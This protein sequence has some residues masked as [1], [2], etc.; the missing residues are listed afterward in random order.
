MNSTTSV[1]SNDVDMTSSSLRRSPLDESLAEACA[2]F[3]AAFGRDEWI[4][5]TFSNAAYLPLLDNWAEGIR[6]LGHERRILV[7]CLDAATVAWCTHRRMGH[8]AQ[9]PQFY[10]RCVFVPRAGIQMSGT[11]QRLWC[12]RTRVFA[13]LARLGRS[14]VHSDT[15]AVWMR[16]PFV[17]G[18]LERRPSDAAAQRWSV[19]FSRATRWPEAVYRKWGFVVCCGLFAVVST[20]ATIVFWQRVRSRTD[21][22]GDDQT[23][24]NG[25]LCNPVYHTEWTPATAD[26]FVWGYAAGGVDP[27]RQGS[28]AEESFS[29]LLLPDHVA[30][31]P[32]GRGSSHANAEDATLAAAVALGSPTG[33]PPYIVHPVVYGGQRAHWKVLQRHGAVFASPPPSSSPSASNQ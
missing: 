10:A 6:R 20:P 23:A 32:T 33:G 7:V 17:T 22:C 8:W 2:A 15:D 11:Q 4:L 30:S 16:D 1:E 25:V 12:F 14:F 24:V 28:A 31:R 9:A 3:V 26:G 27:H 13:S 19:C 18:L 5:V 29:L 21:V